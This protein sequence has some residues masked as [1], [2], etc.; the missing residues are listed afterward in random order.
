MQKRGISIVLIL[1]LLVVPIIN[2]LPPDTGGGDTEFDGAQTQQEI[3]NALNNQQAGTWNIPEGQHV[4]VN[5]VEFGQG[6]LI[7]LSDGGIE[8][9]AKP[10]GFDKYVNVKGAKI[11]NGQ[12]AE[13]EEITIDG[14]VQKNV[15]NVKQENGEITFDEAEETLNDYP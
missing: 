2:G 15:K 13:A 14:K 5:G 6:P 4:T 1:I 9:S 12:I 3:Q 10:V 11:V 8:G 7:V